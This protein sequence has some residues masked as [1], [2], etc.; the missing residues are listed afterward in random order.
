MESKETKRNEKKRKGKI[1]HKKKE[2]HIPRTRTS[3]AGYPVFCKVL[4]LHSVSLYEYSMT[5]EQNKCMNS[6]KAVLFSTTFWWFILE[7]I[8]ILCEFTLDHT[9]RYFDD[10]CA[11]QNPNFRINGQ[12]QNQKSTKFQLMIVTI[13]VLVKFLPF[14]PNASSFDY[15]MYCPNGW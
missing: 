9:L 6:M 15:V 13:K 3:T 10:K 11:C 12:R 5:I 14:K 8:G 2:T 1:V 4:L 7:K